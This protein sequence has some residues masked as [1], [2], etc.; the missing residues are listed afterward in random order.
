MWHRKCLVAAMVREILDVVRGHTSDK[1]YKRAEAYY[2]PRMWTRKMKRRLH[3]MPVGGSVN[4]F[5]VSNDCG[6][7]FS[8][9][10]LMWVI[11]RCTAM[12]LNTG[13]EVRV[14]KP[15]TNDPYTFTHYFHVRHPRH[16]DDET[17]NIVVYCDERS[18]DLQVQA[19]WVVL[20]GQEIPMVFY[21]KGSDH[22]FPCTLG[23]S[24][25]PAVGRKNMWAIFRAWVQ[26]RNASER[27]WNA[28][29]RRS[30]R[31]ASKQVTFTK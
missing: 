22:K 15:Y 23:L 26:R 2:K 3:A 8:A 16:T 19:A 14:M 20:L 4:I 30:Q 7:P 10:Q 25:Y 21:A 11:M 28:M 6:E 17:M 24:H 29:R 9:F 12:L 5:T 1:E 27:K 31:L 13:A 18:I